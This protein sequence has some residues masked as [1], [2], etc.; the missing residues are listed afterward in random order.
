MNVFL[1]RNK[2]LMPT[3]APQYTIGK[4]RFSPLE[5]R[6]LKGEDEIILTQ[7]ETNLLHFFC[8]HVNKVLR[9]ED[10][11]NHVWGKNDYF[12]GRSMDVYVA[13]L[14]KLLKSE[15]GVLIETIPQAGYR[16]VL[17]QDVKK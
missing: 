17:Q 13:K 2:L 14:R 4:L 10:I 8:E 1:R 3:A 16:M 5:N 12:L 9:R 11:L 7:K 6:L 15:E